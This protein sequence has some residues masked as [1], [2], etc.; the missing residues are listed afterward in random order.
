MLKLWEKY[1]FIPQRMNNYIILNRE[2]Q[3]TLN[4]LRKTNWSTI[5]VTL[6]IYDI[7]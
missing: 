2:D 5:D 7:I 4:M 6:I 3:T 1:I